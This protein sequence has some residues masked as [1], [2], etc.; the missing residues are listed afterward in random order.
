V[1][2]GRVSEQEA[3][4]KAAQADYLLLRLKQRLIVLP[5][6]VGIVDFV[7][8]DGRTP[9]P[10]TGNENVAK[11]LTLSTFR[12]AYLDTHRPSLEPRTIEGIELHFKHLLRTLGERFPI[13]EMKLADLQGYVDARA[14]ARG[15][16]G[17]RLSS[18]TIRKEIV[19]L[20]T[21]WNWAAKMGLVSGRFPNDG[22]RFPKVN[23]KPPFMTRE[24]IERRIAAGGLKPYQIKEL[25]NALFLTLPEIVEL[26][27]HIRESGTL[28]W[29][30]PMMCFAA[31]TG[32]RRSELLRVQIA[33]IDFEG[34]AVLINEKK[35]ARGKRTT[36]RVPMSAFL[37][38]VLKEWLAVHPGGPYLF[39]NPAEVRRSRKRSRTTGHKGMRTRATTVRGRLADLRERELPGLGP[40]TEDEAHDHLRRSLR[41][42]RWAVIKGWHIARHSFASNCAAKGVDQRLIDRWLGHTTDEMRRRYQ[43]LIPHQEQQAIGVVFG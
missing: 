6:G 37:S 4:A 9:T 32:A 38:G 3:R 5:P 8:Y 24:E 21:A 7:R 2:I 14:K 29:V 10:P 18:A 31:H 25:W 16:H 28:P 26:L 20:R 15:M 23:E 22:L 17:R 19:S 11:D 41:G 12:D 35:R 42:S 1:T 43:H 13:R 34:T 40:L 30:Y 36:R 39:C 27:V 33:D